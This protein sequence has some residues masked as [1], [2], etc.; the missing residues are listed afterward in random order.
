MVKI[1]KK[2]EEPRDTVLTVRLS[3]TER[4]RLGMLA[5]SYGMSVGAYLIGLALGNDFVDTSADAAS[6][7]PDPAQ[8]RLGGF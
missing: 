5:D 1:R 6:E 3:Q 7:K 8:V 2:L 4:R